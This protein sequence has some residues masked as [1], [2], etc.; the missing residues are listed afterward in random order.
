MGSQKSG[1]VKSD[2][3]DETEQELFEIEQ[4]WVDMSLLNPNKVNDSEVKEG[5]MAA[6]DWAEGGSVKTMASGKQSEPTSDAETSVVYSSDEESGS[7]EEGG[8]SGGEDEESFNSARESEE[9]VVDLVASNNESEELDPMNLD[10][11]LWTDIADLEDPV[12]ELFQENEEERENIWT[13]LLGGVVTSEVLKLAE[14]YKKRRDRE[15]QLDFE[16]NELIDPETHEPGAE[17]DMMYASLEE[18]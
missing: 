12:M 10:E 3:M 4:S 5:E 1:V 8:S 15:I 7:S 18:E 6:F 17:F 13:M 2:L 16:M 11:K 9:D 14:K